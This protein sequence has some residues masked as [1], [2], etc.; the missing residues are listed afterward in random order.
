MLMLLLTVFFT[1]TVPI[2]ATPETPYLDAWA[3]GNFALEGL[4]EGAAQAG[5]GLAVQ[6]LLKGR[7]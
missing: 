3:Q 6:L 2:P 7:G 4:E 5:G 1:A